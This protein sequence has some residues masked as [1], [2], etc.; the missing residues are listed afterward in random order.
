[1]ARSGQSAGKESPSFP[2]YSSP[3]SL[4]LASPPPSSRDTILLHPARDLYFD[5][6]AAPPPADD[7]L[8]TAAKALRNFGIGRLA[9]LGLLWNWGPA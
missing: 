7:G 6:F 3:S 9:G 4:Y 5:S 1:M 8:A 2:P